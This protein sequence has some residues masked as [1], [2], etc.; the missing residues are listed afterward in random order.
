[1]PM[2]P[3]TSFRLHADQ[4][5]A[6]ALIAGRRGCTRTDLIREAID[7]AIAAH[8]QENAPPADNGRRAEKLAGQERGNVQATPT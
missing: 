7:L 2:T 8:D 6:L 1:M 5:A 3:M 4:R